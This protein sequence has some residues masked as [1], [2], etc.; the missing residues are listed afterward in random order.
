MDSDPATID[1]L[2]KMGALDFYAFAL[3]D[4]ADVYEYLKKVAWFFLL[5]T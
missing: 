3:G 5:A 1:S 4:S 2:Q